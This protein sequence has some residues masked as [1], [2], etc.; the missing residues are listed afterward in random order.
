MTPMIAIASI[1]S[2]KLNAQGTRRLKVC[3]NIWLP[4]RILKLVWDDNIGDVPVPASC[5]FSS[6]SLFV[7]TNNP[8]ISSLG[9]RPPENKSDIGQRIRGT[10]SGVVL[11]RHYNILRDRP[12]GSYFTL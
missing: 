6:E 4:I 9:H 8:C 3:R 10:Q 12:T 7:I 1:N 5:N 2:I 11:G